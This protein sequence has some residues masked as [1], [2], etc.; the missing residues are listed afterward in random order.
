MAEK[1]RMTVAQIRHMLKTQ[2]ELDTVELSNARRA[3]PSLDTLKLIEHSRARA[4]FCKELLDKI[5][6]TKKGK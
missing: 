2:L 4:V 6:P 3:L 5:E 1:K